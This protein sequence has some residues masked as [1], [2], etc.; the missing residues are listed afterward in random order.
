MSPIKSTQLGEEKHSPPLPH[1]LLHLYTERLSIH[2]IEQNNVLPKKEMRKSF[3]L[4]MLFTIL[5]PWTRQPCSIVK[6]NEIATIFISHF[7][8]S[9]PSSSCSAQLCCLLRCYLLNFTFAFPFSP[10]ACKSAGALSE[11]KIATEQQQ[12]WCW[13]KIKTVSIWQSIKKA[14]TTTASKT[15]AHSGQRGLGDSIT[16]PASATKLNLMIESNMEISHFNPSPPRYLDTSYIHVVDSIRFRFYL[17]VDFG[18]FYLSEIGKF[19]FSLSYFIPF[20]FRALTFSL[21]LF[22]F[23]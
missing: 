20:W 19:N 6:G 9:P 18:A 16:E 11:I 13:R 14:E 10:F 5:S 2:K 15:W 22:P 1:H 21:S 12:R 23:P 7:A 4:K 3:H 17:K 8:H